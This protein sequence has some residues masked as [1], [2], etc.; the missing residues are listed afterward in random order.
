[1]KKITLTLGTLVL[2]LSASAFAASTES[3]EKYF[4]TID[5]YLENISKDETMKSQLDMVKQQYSQS[6]EQMSA[7]PEATQDQACQQGQ[8][9][10]ESAMKASGISLK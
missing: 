7:L 3:C 2:F 10:L 6:K 9:A 8:A 4:K 5:T 1:M